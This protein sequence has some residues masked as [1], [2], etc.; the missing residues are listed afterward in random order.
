MNTNGKVKLFS[1]LFIAMAALI[2]AI[3]VSA[4]SDSQTI[5]QSLNGTVSGSSHSSSATTQ[6]AL[7]YTLEVIDKRDTMAVGDRYL[8]VAR[9]VP[10]QTRVSIYWYSTNTAVLEVSADGWVTAVAPGSADIV[11]MVLDSSVYNAPTC[12]LTV[13][14]AETGITV[15]VSQVPAGNKLLPIVN[16]RSLL[17]SNYAPRLSYI[18][19]SVPTMHSNLQLTPEALYAYTK[20]YESSQQCGVGEIYVISGYRSYARQSELFSQRIKY[21]TDRGFE[22][23]A[24]RTEAEKTVMPPGSSEHQLGVS[25][26][27]STD[28]N[29]QH[30][31]Q[32]LPQGRWITENAHLFGFV[33][34]YPEDKVGI[35][36]IN[37]EPWHLRYVG[38]EHASYMYNHGLCLE[39]YVAL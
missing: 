31:F 36:G 24:A 39:E 28:G 16:S 32:Q 19:E 8:F 30:N 9:T 35:T 34:R 25:I 38:V 5:S 37:Y 3:A 10:E 29:T 23:N 1:L 14:V 17:S 33:I 13:T 15:P 11:A 20:L 12:T 27:I 2:S 22:Q 6:N 7:G 21:F 26:D 4:S 18:G